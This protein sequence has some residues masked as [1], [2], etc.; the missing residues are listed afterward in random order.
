MSLIA[1]LVLALLLFTQGA[2][3]GAACSMPG[4]SP[5]QAIA[6]AQPMPCHHSELERRNA[7]LCLVDCL[8]FDQS[9]DTPQLPALAPDPAPVLFVALPRIAQ[10]RSAPRSPRLAAH[11]HPPPR[12]LFQSFLI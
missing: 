9:T 11:A 6:S 4:R 7:N 8:S 2:L 12:I 5:A 3:A 1:R 10:P